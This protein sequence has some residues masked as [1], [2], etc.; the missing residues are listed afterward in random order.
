MKLDNA[1][2]D[3]VLAE[4]ESLGLINSTEHAEILSTLDD[5]FPFAPTLEHTDSVHAH[6]KVDDVDALPHEELTARGYR[7]ENLEPG[8]VK[9][10]TDAGL[11]LIFSSI[12]IAADDSVAGAVTM[13]KPFMD[14]VGIDMRDESTPTRIAFDAVPSRVRKLGWRTVAQTGPVHCCHTQVKGKHWAYPPAGWTGW[15]RPIEFAFGPLVIF[16]KVMGC[17][18]RPMDPG[19]PLALS[20]G[21]CC[22]PAPSACD[23]AP[24]TSASSSAASGV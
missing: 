15:R 13:Q 19:H 10:A 9:Y 23:A 24:A 22:G 7:A 6:I 8:Y 5:D 21:S 16:D 4:V 1:E 12:P 20:G 18:L 14:H 11:N 2:V 3:R 17:D